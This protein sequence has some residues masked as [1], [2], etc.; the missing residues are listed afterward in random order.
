MQRFLSRQSNQ[1]IGKY[2]L[3]VFAI[4]LIPTVT[5]ALVATYFFF[6]SSPSPYLAGDKT[7]NW[8]SQWFFIGIAIPSI[9]TLF[10]IYSTSL[11]FDATKK[12]TKSALFGAVPL[13]IV[14][15][16]VQWQLG[17]VLGWFFFVQAY[18]FIE[19]KKSSMSLRDRFLF[20]TCIHGLHNS[21]AVLGLWL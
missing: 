9:E 20:V 12:H 6:E 13:L 5:L 18:V 11:A 8:L 15:S 3:K 10:L 17:L 16:L 19:L 21:L 7:I 14:H 1:L 2:F 4:S